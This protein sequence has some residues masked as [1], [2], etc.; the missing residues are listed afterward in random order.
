MNYSVLHKNINP[1]IR[2]GQRLAYAYI[3]DDDNIDQQTCPGSTASFVV[4]RH[5]AV[6]QIR[7]ICNNHWYQQTRSCGDDERHQHGSL[8]SGGGLYNFDIYDK[9]DEAVFQTC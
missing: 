9:Q 4:D 1:V 5:P 8:S 2:E 3:I 6:Q 7:A